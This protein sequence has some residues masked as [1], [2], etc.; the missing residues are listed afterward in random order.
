MKFLIPPRIESLLIVKVTSILLFLWDSSLVK[1][2]LEVLSNEPISLI[3]K[4]SLSTSLIT[5]INSS[6]DNPLSLKNS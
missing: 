6:G 3:F 5:F 2:L 4:G 1:I